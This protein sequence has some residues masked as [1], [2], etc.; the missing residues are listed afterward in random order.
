MICHHPGMIQILA[1]LLTQLQG[2]PAAAVA[3]LSHL[4]MSP[5]T[6]RSFDAVRDVHAPIS[7][8]RARNTVSVTSLTGASAP[9]KRTTLTI[10]DS[11][12]A[13]L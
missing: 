4:R 3:V 12:V 8:G 6:C 13:A 10:V 11:V 2:Q 9:V 5:V 1:Q 7:E